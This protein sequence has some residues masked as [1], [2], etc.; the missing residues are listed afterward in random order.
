[1]RAALSS[2]NANRPKGIVADGQNRLQLY[3]N[4]A[5]TKAADYRPLVIAYRNGAAVRL[6][7]V[8]DG[9]LGDDGGGG[10]D[11]PGLH[12]TGKGL[13]L[14]V[15]EP[16]LGIRW[17]GGIAHRKEGRQGGHQVEGRV[18][19][20]REQAHGPAGDPGQP[21]GQHQSRGQGHRQPG[22]MT[23]QR[24]AVLGRHGPGASGSVPVTCM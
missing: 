15:T 23:G 3:T 20:G 6:Q 14:A 17:G 4:D 13:G 22:H 18:A 12:Q 24:H 16:V 19:E 8:A 11:Q 9:L 10:E 7:D 2:A 5:A 1:M 21:L